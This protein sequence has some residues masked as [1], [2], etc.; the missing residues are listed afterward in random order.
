MRQSC[1]ICKRS[2]DDEHCST[3]CPHKGIGYCAVC[4][5]TMCN[6]NPASCSDWERASA[7]T[8]TR[9][10][11]PGIMSPKPAADEASQS[12]AIQRT[13]GG[14]VTRAPQSG[15]FAPVHVFANIEEALKIDKLK[16]MRG[17]A[18]QFMCIRDQVLILPCDEEETY[19]GSFN[20]IVPEKYRQKQTEGLVIAV[21][22]GRIDA[23]NVWIA[24]VVRP[25][26][27]VLYGKYAGT[28]YKLQGKTCRLIN[29]EDI[30]GVMR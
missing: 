4:D 11:A 9:Y 6:C 29:E 1:E 25:G 12:H 10:D 17:E 8:E 27:R 16:S 28:E 7:N 2:Y 19:E 15:N 21:G 30:G 18:R 22:P 5:C 26:D 24:T 20:L 13:A 3:V 14:E 23:N